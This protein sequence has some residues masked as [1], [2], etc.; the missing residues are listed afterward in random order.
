[1]K[2]DY[3]AK[4]IGEFYLVADRY[5]F[6]ENAIGLELGVFCNKDCFFHQLEEAGAI[7]DWDL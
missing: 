6:N 3:C 7:Q 4:Q 2:C 5:F 1:M